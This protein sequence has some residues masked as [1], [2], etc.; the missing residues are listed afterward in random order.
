MVIA[1]TALEAQVERDFPGWNIRYTLP[2]TW[3]VRQTPGRLHVLGSDSEP[4][5]LFVAPGL[6]TSYEDV[7]ADLGAF[8]EIAGLRGR[9]VEG[10]VDTTIA[11]FRAVVASYTGVGRS[12]QTVKARMAALFTP[13]GTGLVVLGL[14]APE[15]FWF[16]KEKL[17]VVAEAVVAA[18]PAID[19]VAVAG[20]EGT[21]ANYLA[22]RPPAQDPTDDWTRG[23]NDLFEFD[24]AGNYSWKSSTYLAAEAR[25][26]INES[27]MLADQVE[28][29]TYTVIIGG[30]LILKSVR[31][32]RMV[33]AGVE[34]ERLTLG[35]RT[36]FKRPR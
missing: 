34:A 12:N 17:I 15:Q 35:G 30:T 28:A 1:P 24:A 11:G 9:E 32:Q 5:A 23:V 33:V 21:W 19:T 14:S 36:Y 13:Y 8:V 10:P 3:Y 18:P 22:G 4:G 6:Y 31:G 26:A 27:P 29:G 20:L 16:L 7:D 25:G 2:A